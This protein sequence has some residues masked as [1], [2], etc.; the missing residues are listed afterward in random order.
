MKIHI[1]CL[2]CFLN[3]F[4]IAKDVALPSK[5]KVIKWSRARPLNWD[6]FQAK[7]NSTS[8]FAALS[9]TGIS[10]SLTASIFR[11]E[12]SIEFNV[13]AYFTP[14]ESWVNPGK[15]MPELLDHEQLHFDIVEVYVR[16]IRKRLNQLS[17]TPDNY[18]Q[19]TDEVLEQ[20]SEEL[21]MTHT[22]YDKETD[23]GK[24]KLAQQKWR[25][26]ILQQL[27]EID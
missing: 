19:L 18:R 15:R 22:I 10:L 1:L 11:D 24:N 16:K 17:F 25:L 23:F 7:A 13:Y 12:I 8:E 5:G 2:V 14:T 4:G 9:S 20:F 6:D 21:D 27:I 3:F 26:K